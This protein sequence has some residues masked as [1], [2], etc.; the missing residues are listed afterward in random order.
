MEY[1]WQA[2]HQTKLC[3][4][5]VYYISDLDPPTR[6]RRDS[7]ENRLD[8][9]N[10]DRDSSGFNIKLRALQSMVSGKLTKNQ[11]HKTLGISCDCAIQRPASRKV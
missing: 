2:A 3:H 7:N 9:G 11:R 5:Y 10:Y 6:K 4:Y 8:L 1:F